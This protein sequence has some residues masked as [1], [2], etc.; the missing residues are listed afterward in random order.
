M[1]AVICDSCRSISKMGGG[2]Q[3]QTPKGWKTIQY[4][5]TRY[6]VCPKCDKKV[7]KLLNIRRKYD[8]KEKE[9]K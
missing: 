6:H 3:Y 9:G 4:S 2:Y 7:R 1:M 8:K 5:I